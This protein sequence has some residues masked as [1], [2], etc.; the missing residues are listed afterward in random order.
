MQEQSKE[1]NFEGQN[2]FVG[3]DVHLK[4]WQVTILTEKLF[5]KTFTQPSDA[6]VLHSYLTE[7]FPKGN[8]HSV[9]EA[10]F[11][12]FWAHYRLKEMGINNIVVNASDVPTTQKEKLH[13]DDVVDSNKLAR[14]LRNGEL[15]AI[16]TPSLEHLQERSLVRCRSTLVKDM[17]R[18]KQRIKS[19]LYFYGVSYPPEFER[20]GSHWSKR[21]M[22]WLK[23]DVKLSNSE[24]QETLLLLIKQA[25]SQR[26][27]LLETTKKIKEMAKSDKYRHSM[28]LL[29]SI[30]G[31]GF[32]T[33]ITLLTEIEDIKRFDNTDHLAS[34]VGLV[35][36]SHSSGDKSKNTEMTF[37]GHNF[38]KEMLIESSWVAARC[39]PALCLAFHKYAA[40]MESNKAIIRIARKLLN[41]IYFVL[42]KKQTY[43]MGVV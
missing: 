38:I 5:Y 33:A 25:E 21:F 17:T 36:G 19:F 40:R 15:R 26:D 16:Y 1:F 28:E 42:T 18:F 12:G 2:I 11:S 30:P 8:Y 13:K 27:I 7:H 35:P 41:R 24:G 22:N 23:Y 39:D 4:S 34:Y 9:Y 32:V 3:I 10:G 20:S 43:V 29:Q 31:I 14:S 37:R 6:K